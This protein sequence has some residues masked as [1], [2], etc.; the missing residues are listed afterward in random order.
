MWPLSGASQV[1]QPS[2]G[3]KTRLGGTIAT[4]TNLVVKGMDGTAGI[5]SG[6]LL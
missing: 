5:A 4:K 6:L 1:P 3:S 2:A